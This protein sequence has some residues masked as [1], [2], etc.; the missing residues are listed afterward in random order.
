MRMVMVTKLCCRL[1][2]SPKR[3]GAATLVGLALLPAGL[4]AARRQ[5]HRSAAQAHKERHTY[6]PSV[7]HKV[8]ERGDTLWRLCGEV[9][10]KPWLWPQV[11]ALNPGIHNPHWLHPGIVVAFVPD[12]HSAHRGNPTIASDID[13]PDVQD[14]APA[15]SVHKAP[16]VE[17]VSTNR[18]QTHDKRT[19]PQH[20]FTGSFVSH[21]EL[22][23]AGKL[24]NAAPDKILLRSG[25]DLFV[26]FPKSQTPNIG[27]RFYVFRTADKIR[28]PIT[29]TSWGYM[30]E[31]TGLATVTALQN[32]V[33]RAK[34]DRTVLEVERGQRVM[35][36]SEDLLLDV[37]PSGHHPD[38][39]G[40]VLA[41]QGARTSV[42]EQAIVFLDKGRA[43]GVARG[44]ELAVGSAGDPVRKSSEAL[45]TLDMATLM[46]VDAKEHTSTC[47]V[48]DSLYEIRPGSAFHVAPDVAP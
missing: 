9:T 25:D 23:A 27:D 39:S 21:A 5:K 32:E 19:L 41:V 22:A 34:L 6:L 36:Y 35:P 7:D 20:V 11:W 46:V 31:V 10:G 44:D 14:V 45:P 33:A 38:V 30:T 15:P 28:H 18:P 17:V 1:G 37:V 2:L 47:L 24:T 43:E 29:K 26:T 13:L 4:H 8:V 12:G 3:L 40:I 48:V 42:G 16:A